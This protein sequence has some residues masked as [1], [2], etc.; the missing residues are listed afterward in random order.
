MGKGAKNA[1]VCVY[2]RHLP[3]DSEWEKTSRAASTS[4]DLSLKVFLAEYKQ[5]DRYYD[6][7]DDPAFFAAQEFMD[8]V[9]RASWGVCRPDVRSCI[10]PGDLVIFF[11][12]KPCICDS[13]KW[14]YYYIGFGTVKVR[15]DGRWQIWE[16][17]RF[18][19]YRRFYNLLIAP[20][21]QTPP[22]NADDLLDGPD[23][24]TYVHKE[25]FHPY[26]KNWRRRLC[27]YIIFDEN[28]QRTNF[29]LENP[30]HVATY[31]GDEKREEWN[32]DPLTRQLE[33]MLFN[34]RKISRRLRTSRTGFAH[35]FIHLTLDDDDLSKFRG[36]LLELSQA[37]AGREGHST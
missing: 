26:H 35:Q 1:F 23:G 36:D 34:K 18:Q 25:T 4:T 33:N 24:L 9:R 14:D 17:N 3:T 31:L 6:W 11:C 12:G 21:S 7:G 32:S 2:L 13:K 15:V 16:D 10:K 30:L 22:A 29:N 27:A 37:V 19:P 8:D 28:K 20:A 5:D